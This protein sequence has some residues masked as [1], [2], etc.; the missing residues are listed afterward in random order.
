MSSMRRNS[1]CFADS[2]RLRTERGARRDIEIVVCNT[3]VTTRRVG[4]VGRWGE[5]DLRSLLWAVVSTDI[6]PTAVAKWDARL[7][8]QGE[9]TL[10]AT[11]GE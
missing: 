1:C 11:G 8:L 2:V 9:L 7:L 10:M 5:K 6:R 4:G 3:W